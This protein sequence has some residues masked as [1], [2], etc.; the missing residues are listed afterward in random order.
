MSVCVGVLV[1]AGGKR[2]DGLVMLALSMYSVG[3]L[4]GTEKRRLQ[5][6]RCG[7]RRQFRNAKCA[8]GRGRSRACC[9]VVCSAA[10]VV[11]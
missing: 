9:V 1:C 4:L 3:R 7:G 2:G 8:F 11:V 6:E 10:A 5:M